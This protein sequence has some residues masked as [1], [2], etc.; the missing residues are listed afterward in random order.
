MLA[1]GFWVRG[2]YIG[3]ELFFVL[4]GFLITTLLLEEHVASGVIS[5]R[6]FYKRRAR[7]LL[8]VAIAGI[9]AGELLIWAHGAT[10]GFPLDGVYSL[11]YLENFVRVV[12]WSVLGHY[13]SLSQEEQ[14]YFAWPPLLVVLL[15]R[16][17]PMRP[18]AV[19]LVAVAV[20]VAVHRTTLS[21]V[22]RI[23]GPDARA[24]GILLGCALA[25]ARFTGWLRPWRGWAFVGFAALAVYAV[26]AWVADAATQAPLQYG[27]TVGN[28]ASVALLASVLAMPQ[29]RLARLFTAAPLRWL[30]LIS[31]SLYIWNPL[32][33]AAI[34]RGGLVWFAASIATA[35]L[36]YRLIEQPFRRRSAARREVARPALAAARAGPA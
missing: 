19:V 16:R 7:R 11:F 20:A 13:W 6:R 3:V 32:V 4:S 22:N 18:L 27:I 28:V 5:L 9:V 35:M 12:H 30:G 14:F 25:F 34:G 31:Y 1:H 2:G 26:D 23:F 21:D 17:V 33:L 8:P 15:R 10:M 24:D 29:G 36:S